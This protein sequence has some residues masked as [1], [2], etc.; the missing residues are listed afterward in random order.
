MD[1]EALVELGWDDRW[2]EAFAPYADGNNEGPG[3]HRAPRRIHSEDGFRRGAG[4]SAGKD[5]ARGGEQGRPPCGRG[6]GG[7]RANRARGV[8]V[9]QRAPPPL[10]VLPKVANSTTEEQP[11]AVNLDFIFLVASLNSDLNLRRIERYLT[12][13]WESGASPVVV[14]AKADLA[15]DPEGRSRT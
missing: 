12:L 5:A 2:A 10:E 14:L 13:T 3:G 6:L 11:V 4:E 9:Q 8:A 7:T 15:E 1:L